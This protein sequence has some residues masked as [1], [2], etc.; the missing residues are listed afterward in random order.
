[1]KPIKKWKRTS[2][3]V[4]GH[5]VYFNYVL[6]K[7]RLPNG[8]KVDYYAIRKEH[9]AN[10][11]GVTDDCKVVLV[12]Q[13]RALFGRVSLELPC[14]GGGKK[15]RPVTI[16]KREFFEETG[17]R[18]SRALEI[19]VWATDSSIMDEAVHTFLLTGLK[20]DKKIY[21]ANEHTELVL[22]TP[23]KIDAAIADCTIWN[24]QS[25]VAW[26]L[27]RPYILRGKI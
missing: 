27:A 26:H 24:G 7:Y 5:N 4:L 11:V 10:M 13:Y 25:I 9:A 21:D 3:H 1:M 18:A 6:E 8:R 23:S 14:G 20:K 22:M 15:E 2:R 17:Y 16:A 12:R 19:G